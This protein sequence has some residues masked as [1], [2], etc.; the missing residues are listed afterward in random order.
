MHEFMHA[1]LVVVLLIVIHGGCG[2]WG[3]LAL[4]PLNLADMLFDSGC[5]GGCDSACIEP[6]VV[7]GVV[8]RG[9]CSGCR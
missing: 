3:V 2:S 4:H 7:R 6:A 5:V 8:V 9:G 1:G